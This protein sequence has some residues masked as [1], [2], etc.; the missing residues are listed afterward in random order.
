M[1]DSLVPCLFSLNK[2]ENQRPKYKKLLQ[3]PFVHRAKECPQADNV[4]AYLS[5]VIDNL[6]QNTDTFDLYY[7]LPSTVSNH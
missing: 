6:S 7:Y 2:D 1:L 3:H 5:D 4:A